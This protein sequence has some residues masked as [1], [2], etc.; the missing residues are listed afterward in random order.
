M[1][2]EQVQPDFDVSVPDIPLPQETTATGEI[3]D[4][5]DAAF[6]LA[7]IGAGQGGG[8]LASTFYRLGYRR[9]MALNTASQDLATLPI[10][11]TNKM[12][13]GEGG[14]GKNPKVAQA[15]M[16]ERQGDVLDFMR[17][18]FGTGLDR[19][20]VTVGAGGGT[21]AGTVN[22]LVHTARE[23][24]QMTKAP[25]DKVG[26]IVALPKYSESNKV[27]ANAYAVLSN[28]STLVAQRLVSPLIVLD[29]ERIHG[30]YPSLSVDSFW[31]TS[32]LSIC[33]LFHLFNTIASK[34]SHYT[35]F[36]KND[37][38]HVLDSGLI[39]FGATPLS[40]WDD[41]TDISMAIRNNLSKNILSG[42]VTLS[43]GTVAGAVVIGSQAILSKLNMSHLEHG[44]DQL[45]RMLRPNSTV[46]R[47][48]YR[49][50]KDNIVVYTVIG[51]LE[52]PAEKLADLR[53]M[54]NVS[55]EPEPWS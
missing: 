48:I 2:D 33:S 32:N 11:E 16:A 13:I 9:V 12:Q 1:S 28:L 6:R 7:F 25:S 50:D 52:R 10:P 55:V 23:L 19:I 54:G 20:M 46:H 24:L 53:R 40:K 8:R 14:A 21:G 37:L 41:P 49:G 31:D 17:R 51:G 26:V 18:T 45:G 43:S 30:L 5:F 22:G 29:N 3:A 15:I 34:H 38:L 35:S 42:G 44:F 27:M 4:E 47:G 36:D 39:V